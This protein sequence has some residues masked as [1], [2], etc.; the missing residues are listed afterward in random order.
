MNSSL[1]KTFVSRKSFSFVRGVLNKLSK[2][3]V[4]YADYLENNKHFVDIYQTN[5]TYDCEQKINELPFL[6]VNVEMVYP[7][8]RKAN[9]VQ[10]FREKL[11][12]TDFFY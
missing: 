5:N 12:F 6:E 1:E 8:A 2:V 9:F 4:K 7:S 10:L 11:E 3:A